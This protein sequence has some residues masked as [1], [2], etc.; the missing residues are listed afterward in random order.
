MKSKKNFKISLLISIVFLSLLTFIISFIFIISLKPVKINFLNYFDRKSEIFKKIKVKEFGDVYLSFNKISK[1]FELL[2]EDLVIEDSY[3]PNIL[4]GIDLKFKKRIYDLSLKIFD[5]E[6]ELKL[7][8][9]YK[10]ESNETSVLNI[11]QKR[12]NPLENFSSIQIVN[13]KFKFIVG[14]DIYR[15]YFIDINFNNEELVCSLSEKIGFDNYLSFEYFSKNNQ[16]SVNL[17]S[18]KFNFNFLKYFFNIEHVSFENLYLTGSSNFKVNSDR[19]V[20]SLFFN[21][22]LDG[23]LNYRTYQGIE[24]IEFSKSQIYG[25]KKDDTIDVILNLNHYD[26]EFKTALRFN[27]EDAKFSKIY[28]ELDQIKVSELLKIWPNQ[29]QPSVYFWMKDNSI[30]IIRD[31]V[32]SM[33]ILDSEKKIN[34]NNLTG[35]FN[36]FDTK[37]RYM[38]SMPKITDIVGSAIITDKNIKFDILSGLSENLIINGG[39]VDLY[40]LNS[41]FEK[42]HVVLE[43]FSKNQE[44]IRYLNTSPINKKNYVKLQNIY[45]DSSIN[46]ELKFPLILDLLAENIKY[47]SNVVI[48]DAVF[49]EIF[50]NYTLNDFSL[51]INIDNSDVK[52]SGIGS[53][54]NSKARFSG[55]QFVDGNNL[56]EEII[57]KYLIT[58]QVFESLISENNMSYNGNIEI[59]FKI[60][61]NYSGISKIE[62][63]GS[64]GG[65]EL[66]SDFL[67]K[68]LNFENGKLRF[69]IRPYDNLFSGFVDV[70]TSDLEIEINTLFNNDRIIEL[71]VPRFISPLQDF[72]LTYKISDNKISISGNK[73]TL[74]ELDVFEESSLDTHDLNLNL[75]VRILKLGGM[76]FNDSKINFYKSN[77]IFEKMFI[78][79]KGENDFHKISIEDEIDK[80]KF[81]LESNYIPG[82]LNIFDI[83]LNIGQGSLKIEGFKPKN[84]SEYKGVIVG[85]NIVFFD[86]PFFA[87]FFS[88]FSLDG[89]AQK[90]KDGGIIFNSLNANYKFGN[91]KLKIIDSLL[92]GSELGI[93][94][95]TVMGM[96][97]DYFFTNGSII[98][99]YTI[100]TLITKF[101]ILGDI[102]TAGSPE[103]GL[104]GA[105]FR[106][107]KI[108]GEYEVFY[109]PISVFVPDIIKNFLG[110]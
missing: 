110:D 19:S 11:L 83:D 51:N 106:V 68:D 79:L 41:N 81:V 5:G 101:P 42:A 57:G 74:D 34:L 32:I 94:F 33:Q 53:I 61:E 77:N 45:G 44:V 43:I 102:I 49:K 26:S 99:A 28:L 40:D 29:F 92:K 48:E 65:V 55:R 17:E 108:D 86:A 8:T 107:E 104:I 75:E 7:P 73:M 60:I 69:L 6:V 96:N 54:F 38:D 52:Y 31:L 89:F 78:D 14:D 27:L 12:V 15:E 37:I 25:E 9:N 103:D 82:L 2:I 10:I 90:L 84:S 64:L 47:K 24:K 22:N 46:L 93:Q 88:I 13:T 71:D 67:G 100:N 58:N 85:K 105:N 76:R 23:N 21:L 62:G 72:N 95:D 66:S 63:I 20:E 97:D 98:P 3:F 4:I 70:K 1:N 30:G 18:K 39:M 59:D 16:Y 109:N 87:N 50:N 56:E 35:R 80:K 36:F 91:D